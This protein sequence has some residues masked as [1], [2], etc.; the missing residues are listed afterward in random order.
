MR[1]SIERRENRLG[2][3]VVALIA[4]GVLFW[5]MNRLPSWNI[6]Y[7]LDSYSGALPSIN[8]ALSVSVAMN[9]VLL[10]YH[11]RYFHHL[12]QVV[13]AGF[14]IFAVS[15]IARIF[16]LDFSSIPLP[17]GTPSLNFLA[18][19]ALYVVIG[20]TAIGALVHAVKFLAH[21]FRGEV[22]A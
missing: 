6:P 17:P 9:V 4:N 10:F 2:G 16:P 21:L 22:E 8:L 11:P 5:V 18:R 15:A 1:N 13:L 3:Y 20:A 7:L 14:S 19:L 12:A